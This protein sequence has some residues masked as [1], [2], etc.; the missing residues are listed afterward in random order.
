MK[1]SLLSCFLFLFVAVSMA[2][3]QTRTISG[4]VTSAEGG[5]A[6]VGVSVAVR[7]TTM[8]TLTDE[9]G[10]F[11]LEVPVNRTL[12][13]NYIGYI[14]QEVIVRNQSTINIA[15]VSDD[16]AIEEVV[17]TG[18]GQRL[19][20][21]SFTGAST[22]ISGA[23]AHIG[24]LADPSRGLEGRVSGV[25]VQNVSGT[26]GTAPKIRVRGATSIY[27]SSKPLWVI[28]GIIVEDV[29]DVPADDLSSGDALT[30]IS[31]AVAGLN[32][33]DIETFQ[34]LKDGAATSI[35]GARAMAGVIVITTKKGSAGR[36]AINYS[37]E[38]TTRAVP[39]YNEF[40]IMNSQEQMSVYQDMN[41][42]GYLR[43]AGTAVASS[44]GVYG[45]MYELINK[46]ELPNDLF[47][48]NKH[49]NEYLREA[50]YRNTDWFSELFSPNLQHNH[51][52]SMS[53]G[54]EKSQYYA[55]VS[56]LGDQG[57]AK[58]SDVNRYTANLNANFNILE[59]L[60]LNVITSGSHRSQKAP[61]TLGQS[62]DVVFGEVKRDFDINPYSYAMNTSRTLDPNTFYTRNYAPFNI[63]HELENNYMDIN[64]SDVKFQGELKW[65]VLDNLEL[66][67]LGAIRYQGTAQHHHVRDESN[68]ATAHR[69]MPTSTIRDANPYLY[70]DPEN[71]FAIPVT[72][73]PEGGIYNRTDYNMVSTDFRFT[74]QYDKNFGYKHT[75]NL[76]GATTFNTVERSDNWFRGWGMQY[77]M[78]EI[79]FTNYLVFKRGQEENTQYYSLGNTRSKEVAFVG[80]GT[81]TYD[82]KYI[83]NG[84]LRYEGSNRLGRTTSARWMP[85]WNI[86]GAWNMHNE[87]FFMDL[88][89]YMSHFT[90]KSSYSLT[91]DRGPS[92][93]TNSRVVIKSYNPW[94]PSTGDNESGLNI[95]NLENSELTY[96]K[97]HELNIGLNAGFLDNRINVEFDW[98]KRNNFDLIG[99]VNTQGMGGEIS[100]YGNVASMTSN[101]TELS[102]TAHIIKNPE[103]QWTSNF[104][105]TH[106]KTKVTEL[107]TRSRVIDLITGS[108]FA[109]EGRPVRSLF[110][111]PFLGLNNE[112]LPTFLNENN[113]ETIT[114]VYFQEREE[115]DFL[116]YSGSIDPVNVG[117]FGNIFS[118]KNFRLNVFLTYSFGNV[119]RLDPVFKKEYSDLTAT[120]KEFKN[121]WVV[122]GD[123]HITDVPTIASIRQNRN[124][125]NLAYAYNT[126]N[127]STA[128]V[129]KGDFI[130]VKD[131]SFGYEFPKDMITPWKLSSLG[132]RVNATNLFLIY[133][134]KKLNGQD[135]E[136]INSGGVA[137]PIPRQYTLTLKVGL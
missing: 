109:V 55:S 22:Q 70:K 35:Y 135:P 54:N 78:G 80:N 116:N 12:T 53:S 110:S 42:K 103:F 87:D 94:R 102:L 72:V 89:P 15:L 57:W 66:G 121:R 92:F 51:S 120:P 34:I 98:F 38:Y 104:I 49:I 132:L 27:G 111:V 60:R 82:S 123:E 25:S 131:V 45:K 75:L 17:V 14:A 69:W 95:E 107:D 64:V 62:T 114:E 23:D 65:K 106:V 74:A 105:F 83:V 21:R 40:N 18:M 134:D 76:F 32:A 11:T 77:E 30:L 56:A 29:A 97:K 20:K 10:T 125:S 122:P 31:S 50:E 46:G 112:G 48:N 117:S 59:N 113:E 8:G 13:F 16:N 128:R 26:F 61:G 41:Q 63:L 24:G 5:E 101:G 124:N 81:Y 6:M 79:P 86:S 118:Y 7:G 2:M 136:F 73:L 133:A 130:R 37:G 90:L 47:T 67:G 28:D 19:D 44:S 99:I 88:R 91:G 3:A 93:V 126:Y 1:K 84:T 68:Q 96:E 36:S 85:T 129:A 137:A 100:K 52:V 115:L 39:R 127:Y 4:K 119:I 71:P 58:Q 108:G 33:D 43:L 9:N